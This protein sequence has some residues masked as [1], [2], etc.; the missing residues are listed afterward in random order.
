[1][2]M[3]VWTAVALLASLA[4]FGPPVAHAEDQRSLARDLA[5]LMLDDTV[6][7]ELN[8]QVAA[9]LTTA[10]GST[11]QTRLNRRL[12]DM[13][14]RLVAEIV[15]RFVSDTLVPGR[16]DELAADIYVRQ[17]DEAELRE[18]LTFQRSAVG[19]KATRLAPTI[20]VETAEAINQ[21]IQSSPAMPRMVQ[22]LQSVFPVLKPPESQSP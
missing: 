21:E 1:M 3:R 11:L 2:A 16:T 19:R 22:E 7:R 20:A 15:R 9:G 10:V 13:E 6:R 4:G 5:H 18:L 17:F 14:W 8:E 12:L